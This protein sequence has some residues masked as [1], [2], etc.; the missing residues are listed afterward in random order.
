[1]KWFNFGQ[2]WMWV[3]WSQ[4]WL[5]CYSSLWNTCDRETDTEV[6]DFTR[7]GSVR[8]ERSWGCSE[9]QRKA[10]P[11]LQTAECQLRAKARGWPW[12][13]ERG[14]TWCRNA[15]NRFADTLEV[16]SSCLQEVYLL[17]NI[18]GLSRFALEVLSKSFKVS[19][20]S[21]LITLVSLLMP[22]YKG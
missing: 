16:F 21:V 1:M 17:V 12:R 2:I 11:L 19:P 8:P 9:G 22:L 20:K 14:G 13:V 4:R 5:R 6:K 15:R 7:G 3:V 10:Q 18:L